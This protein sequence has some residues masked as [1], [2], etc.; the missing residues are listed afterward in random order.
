MLL[1]ALHFLIAGSLSRLIETHNGEKIST[2]RFRCEDCS[3][4]WNRYN[5]AVLYKPTTAIRNSYT[6]CEYEKRVDDCWPHDTECNFEGKNNFIWTICMSIVLSVGL[7]AGLIAGLF[8]L[9]RKLSN[10]LNKPDTTH[11]THQEMSQTPGQ[12]VEDSN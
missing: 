3:D 6:C 5:F 1:F 10:K 4:G 2:D 8:L 9:F 12:K 11:E 7:I